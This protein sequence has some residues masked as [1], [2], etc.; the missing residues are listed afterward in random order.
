M[1]ATVQAFT[2]ISG[3]YTLCILFG[4]LLKAL[5]VDVYFYELN[6]DVI[7]ERDK[8]KNPV[9]RYFWQC[10]VLKCVHTLCTYLYMY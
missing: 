6:K 1:N 2:R 9:S 4:S 3:K 5:L 10:I 7:K 8:V